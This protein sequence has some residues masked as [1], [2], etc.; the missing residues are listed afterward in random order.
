MARYPFLQKVLGA[1]WK[2]A[3]S[4]SFEKDEEYEYGADDL[5]MEFS[6]ESTINMR[7]G[8]KDPGKIGEDNADTLDDLQTEIDM[9]VESMEAKAKAHIEEE[10]KKAIKGAS[11]IQVD[12]SSSSHYAH[13]DNATREIMLQKLEEIEVTVTVKVFMPVP[14]KEMSESVKKAVETADL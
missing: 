10:V 8:L 9:H 3:Y 1:T 13:E 14:L 2:P 5:A 4:P 7:K 6:F 12:I 11:G